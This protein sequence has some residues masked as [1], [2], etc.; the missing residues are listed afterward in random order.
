MIYLLHKDGDLNLAPSRNLPKDFQYQYTLNRAFIVFHMHELELARSRI[1]PVTFQYTHLRTFKIYNIPVIM[2]LKE[3]LT[4]LKT[5]AFW[6]NNKN[7]PNASP[8]YFKTYLIVLRQTI[9]LPAVKYLS[10]IHETAT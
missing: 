2:T 7:A 9:Y 1:F 5:L 8:P 4:Q 10:L 3:P 6:L